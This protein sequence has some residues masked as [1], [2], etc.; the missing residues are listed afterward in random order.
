MSVVNKIVPSGFRVALYAIFG[1]ATIAGVGIAGSQGDAGNVAVNA[2][3]LVL[4]GGAA[5][6]DAKSQGDQ[7]TAAGEAMRNTQLAK[8]LYSDDPN[9][10][11]IDNVS[12]DPSSVEGRGGSDDGKRIQTAAELFSG[13]D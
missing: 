1:I 10:A 7:V 8:D 5:V 4:V 3:G 13:L 11:L 9:A 12:A 2:I 6:L